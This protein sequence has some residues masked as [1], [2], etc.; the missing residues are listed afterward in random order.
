VGR[1]AWSRRF[2]LQ[3]TFHEKNK[4][5]PDLQKNQEFPDDPTSVGSLETG[6]QRPL[7]GH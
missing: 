6:K 5:L 1:E 4:N 2:S 7:S 3:H